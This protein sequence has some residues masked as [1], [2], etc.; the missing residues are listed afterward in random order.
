MVD[1]LSRHHRLAGVSFESRVEFDHLGEFV[2]THRA[3][4]FVPVWVLDAHRGKIPGGL[5]DP[6][7]VESGRNPSHPPCTIAIVTR[8]RILHTADW[9]VG[10]TIRGRSRIDEHRAVL[11][12]IASVAADHDVDVTLV[13]GDVFDVAAPTPESEQVVYRALLD[14][15]EV[16]P[17]VVVAGNHDNPRRL[18]AVAPLLELGR[19]RVAGRIA[20]PDQGGVLGDLGIPIRVALMPWQSQRGIVGAA[21]LMLR[22]AVDQVQDYAGRMRRVIEA[23]TGGLT[24]DTVNVIVSH[25]MVY[26]AI[27]SGSERHAQIFG[28]AVPANA[29][30]G[31]LSY[32]A[33][34]HLH[35]QQQ[36]PAPAPMWYSG[37]PL[38][39]DFGESGQQK[40]VLVVE[41]EPGLP[42]T[43]TPI[44]LTAGCPLVHL[45]G[46]LEQV[47]AQA[48][49]L[50]EAYVKVE[51]D[52]PGRVGLADRVREIVPSAVEV[53]LADRGRP[54]TGPPKE[55]LGRSATD[56]FAEY[57]AE[58]NTDDADLVRLFG[59][60]LE[61][62]HEA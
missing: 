8:L 23:M 49:D 6:Q 28:Y 29:F 55:R 24:T 54:D 16:A 11:A 4:P 59:E 10:R 13:A 60:L 14:L 26:G 50:G 22:D 46:T 38:Q 40:G 56:L 18:T 34:G 31:S 42:A 45:R 7:P 53:V 9:H 48:A 17:V 57:L 58:R 36:I 33:L 43:V 51:L 2:D 5:A 41:A 39:L 44:D 21:D 12:E 3:E 62:A 35:R 20:R 61:E 47:E 1:P 27:E 25:T 30:P 52:E 32:V 19:V 15:A 37:S